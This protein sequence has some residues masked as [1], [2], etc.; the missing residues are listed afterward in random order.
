MLFSRLALFI[1]FVLVACGRSQNDV[2]PAT[3]ALLPGT[4]SS[5]GGEAV[6]LEFQMLA[7]AI[8]TEL[9]GRT[10]PDLG[11]FPAAAWNE[12][13]DHLKIETVDTPIW[14]NGHE[15]DAQNFPDERR[16]R[17]QQPRW[18][19]L[20]LRERERLVIHEMLSLLR[21]AD[22]NYR[23]TAKIAY[24]LKRT[25]SARVSSIY[26]SGPGANSL[27]R[28]VSWEHLH[29]VGVGY[30]GRR[31]IQLDFSFLLHEALMVACEF[32]GDWEEAMDT[33][34]MPVGLVPTDTWCRIHAD[35]TL[36][37]GLVQ[38][39]VTPKLAPLWEALGGT[40]QKGFVYPGLRGVRDGAGHRVLEIEVE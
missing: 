24:A 15:V 13:L 19:S 39:P 40:E 9:T 12:T 5:G 17:V 8:A 10:L 38:I 31:A 14:L 4:T 26:L 23:L 25:Y 11:L 29:V 37:D 36:R 2:K 34:R 33:K 22:P 28:N 18:H 20:G 3:P 6:E 27:V 21:L 35:G 32:S 7:R 30:T 1:V 16:V